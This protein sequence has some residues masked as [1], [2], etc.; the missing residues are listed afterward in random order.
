MQRYVARKE[1]KSAGTECNIPYTGARAIQ[2]GNHPSNLCTK[3]EKGSIIG[4]AMRGEFRCV[5]RVW[6]SVCRR[7]VVVHLASA[8]HFLF[9][10]RFYY[11]PEFTKI[12]LVIFNCIF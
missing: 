12:Q 2:D 8:L 1:T 6:F 5:W 10:L 9:T 11:N 7:R 3:T 4:P